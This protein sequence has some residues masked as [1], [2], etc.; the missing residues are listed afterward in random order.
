MNYAL[1]L[2]GLPTLAFD[3]IKKES[4]LLIVPDG[5][6]ITRPNLA[7]GKYQK[8]HAQDLVKEA[9]KYL[10]KCDEATP[11]SV[12]VLYVDYKEET[13]EEFLSQFFPFGLPLAIDLPDFG[14]ARNK[15]AL[16]ALLNVF[17]RRIIESVRDLKKKARL[18][19]E[20]TNVANLTPLLLPLENFRASGLQTMLWEIF[21][22]A[23]AS[24]NP[25]AL[26]KK[27]TTSFLAKH[28]RVVPPSEGRGSQQHCFSDGT[29][30]FKSPGKNRHGFLRNRDA[31]MHAPPCLLNARSRVGGS[32][33]Y[34]FHFDCVPC[35]GALK[36]EYPNCHGAM[37]P[38]KETHVNVAPN[39][40]II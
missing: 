2:G 1:V 10:A 9:S 37:T 22:S 38:P 33:G 6:L 31:P 26:I 5:K 13:T 27:A 28:P 29:L 4:E 36:P 39:D 17:V 35:K 34:T 30:F 14:S 18:V 8:N 32:Y 7:S 24:D 16:N 12:I 3:R 20:E 15:N 11:T 21:R 25:A 40:Y 23:G 19:A